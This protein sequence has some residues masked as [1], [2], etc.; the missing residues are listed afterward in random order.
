MTPPKAQ[1]GG[2]PWEL[3]SKLIQQWPG[4]EPPGLLVIVEVGPDGQ[5]QVREHRLS[6][7][8]ELLSYLALFE[9]EQA[10]GGTEQRPHGQA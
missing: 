10:R 5:Q 1:T 8:S 2:S 6:T 3:L 9:T 7:S 4:Q